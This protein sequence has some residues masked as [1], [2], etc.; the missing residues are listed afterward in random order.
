MSSHMVSSDDP[1]A[2]YIVNHTVTEH[3]A[4]AALREVTLGHPKLAGSSVVPKRS[5]YIV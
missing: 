2:Q 1:L 3:P 4:Q 5:P